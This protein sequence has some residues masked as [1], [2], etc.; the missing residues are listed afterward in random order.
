MFTNI[1]SNYLV[2][3]WGIILI[4]FV[5]FYIKYLCIKSFAVINL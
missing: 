4:I 1:V 2:K 3:D 5:P